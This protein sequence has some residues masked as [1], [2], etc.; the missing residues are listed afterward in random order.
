[1]L[2]Y[3]IEKNS[4]TQQIIPERDHGIDASWTVFELPSRRQAGML[5]RA[6]QMFTAESKKHRNTSEAASGLL[7][8]KMAFRSDHFFVENDGELRKLAERD[9]K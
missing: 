2:R 1:M 5:C 8:L 4:D 3:L 7:V 6:G 9:L